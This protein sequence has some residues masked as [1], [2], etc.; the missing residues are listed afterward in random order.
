MP[1]TRPPCAPLRPQEE[2]RSKAG[3]EEQREA[4]M[5]KVKRDNA[6]ADQVRRAGVGWVGCFFKGLKLGLKGRV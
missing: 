5:A 2:E 4:L 6:E 3:P 1:L